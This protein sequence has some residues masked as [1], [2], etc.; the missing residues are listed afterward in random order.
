VEDMHHTFFYCTVNLWGLEE[1]RPFQFSSL[2][3]EDAWTAKIPS[4]LSLK[5]WSFVLLTVLWWLWDAR[6]GEIFPW[7]AAHSRV[8]ISRVCDNFVTWRKR[9]KVPFG[10][11]YKPAE[12]HCWLIFCERK[13]LF[14]LKKQAE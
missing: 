1:T 5:L 11:N 13:I 14:R 7:E 9:L 4:S 8:I 10:W 2:S 3:D 6:N 12:K